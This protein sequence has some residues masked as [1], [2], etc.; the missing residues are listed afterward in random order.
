MAIGSVCCSDNNHG[1]NWITYLLFLLQIESSY[2]L[3]VAEEKE[4]CD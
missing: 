4:D 3:T 2:V 1:A